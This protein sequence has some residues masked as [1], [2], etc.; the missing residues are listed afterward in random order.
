MN[1]LF[2]DNH[3]LK[4][5]AIFCRIWRFLVR[6]FFFFVW[7]YREIASKS[8]G[9]CNDKLT[10]SSDLQEDN[11]DPESLI[12]DTGAIIWMILVEVH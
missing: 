12:W 1:Y 2:T 9:S 8:D 10:F 6:Y 7:Y 4:L 11:T 3:N 5:D